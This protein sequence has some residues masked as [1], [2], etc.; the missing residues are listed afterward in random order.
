MKPMEVDHGR[1][2]AALE[3]DQLRAAAIGRRT[4]NRRQAVLRAR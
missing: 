4:P 3:R 2:A 1:H